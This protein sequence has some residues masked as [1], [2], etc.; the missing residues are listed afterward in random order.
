MAAAP[1]QSHLNRNLSARLYSAI[2]LISHHRQPDIIMSLL[3]SFEFSTSNTSLEPVEQRLCHLLGQSRIQLAQSWSQ[4]L[5]ACLLESGVGAE[6]EVIVSALAPASL[7]EAITL[8]GA[9]PVFVDVESDSLL[10]SHRAIERAVSDNTKAVIVSHLYGQIFD[11]ADL[12]ARLHDHKITLIEDGSD[13]F[14]ALA[15]HP[16]T[17]TAPAQHCDYLITCLPQS[18][19]TETGLPSFILSRH[20]DKLARLSRWTARDAHD[21]W[22]D[23]QLGSETLLGL[24][25][26]MDEA[27]STRLSLILDELSDEQ[28]RLQR[29]ITR[30]QA[31]FSQAPLRLLKP[32]KSVGLGQTAMP[33]HVP[34]PFRDEFFDGLR[35]AGYGVYQTYRSLPDLAY[36]QKRFDSLPCPNARRWTMGALGLPTGFL[37]TSHEQSLLINHM[38]ASL[39]PRILD[40]LFH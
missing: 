40:Q 33:V 29:Q 27:T 39:F 26:S 37:I 19:E 34:P 14:L 13:A 10:A 7:A 30:Y 15:N 17:E 24:I 9:K 4:A 12:Y 5:L 25:N 20:E 28:K 32:R 18:R 16:S 8:V 35:S 6:D 1:D 36:F 31:A 11:S 23:L 3:S 2:K 38:E 21:H 22:I